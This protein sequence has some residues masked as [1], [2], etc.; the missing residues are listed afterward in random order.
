[1]SPKFAKKQA[2][3]KK[4]KLLNNFIRGGYCVVY[5]CICFNFNFDY[6]LELKM[7]EKDIYTADNFLDWATESEKIKCLDLL[8]QHFDFF[9]E[10]K[11][12]Y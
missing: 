4:L 6:F 1:M 9:I 3:E 7:T 12:K 5:N 11:K 8:L 10:S 2:G